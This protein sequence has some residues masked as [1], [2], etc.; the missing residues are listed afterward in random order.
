M[1]A[2]EIAD[3]A[4][5]IVAGYA[6]FQK[7]EYVEVIDLNDLN[8]RAIIQND[9]VVESLMDDSEDDVVLDYYKRNCHILREALY[10]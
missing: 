2:K 6:Y 8:K 5:M 4:D 3:K 1:N 7:D 9:E 10:A